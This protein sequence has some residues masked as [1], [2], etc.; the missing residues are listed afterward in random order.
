MSEQPDERVAGGGLEG[1][2][3]EQEGIP[4]LAEDEIGTER[5]DEQS[6]APG[7]EN[8]SGPLP[9]EPGPSGTD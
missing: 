4:A 3:S 7:Q 2:V 1:T 9:D 6:A 8:P 5:G